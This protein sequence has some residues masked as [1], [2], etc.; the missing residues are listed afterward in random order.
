MNIIWQISTSTLVCKPGNFYFSNIKLAKQLIY[1]DLFPRHSNG[2]FL[3]YFYKLYAWYL[4]WQAWL[5]HHMVVTRVTKD[6]WR[7]NQVTWSHGTMTSSAHVT[8]LQL[9]QFRDDSEYLNCLNCNQFFC[10]I[11]IEWALI[12]RLQ[13]LWPHPWLENITN[14]STSSGGEVK[15]CWGSL[16]AQPWYQFI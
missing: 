15:A 16:W 5:W 8:M 11:I 13:A 3:A 14:S 2:Y 7:N 6:Y 10:F 9:V 4:L 1:L 12:P